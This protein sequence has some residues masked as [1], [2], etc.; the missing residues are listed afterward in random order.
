MADIVERLCFWQTVY[1]EDD[2]KPEGHLYQEAAE[3]IERLRYRLTVFQQYSGLYEYCKK[4]LQ[5][6]KKQRGWM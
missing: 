1:P 6:K 3:E 5:N 4:Q 2:H